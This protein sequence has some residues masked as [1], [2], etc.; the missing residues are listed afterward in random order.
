MHATFNRAWIELR[1]RPTLSSMGGTG[2]YG[3]QRHNG[4]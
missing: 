3:K 2:T 1:R 4:N